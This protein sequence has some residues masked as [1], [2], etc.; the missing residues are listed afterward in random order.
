MGCSA[1]ETAEHIVTMCDHWRTNIMVERHDEVPRV[2]YTA[3]KK[4]YEV[5]SGR[6]GTH[7]AYE[8]GKIK[9]YGGNGTLPHDTALECYYLGAN[10]KAA[11]QRDRK[12]RVD[13][14][15][16][17]IGA[18]GECTPNLRKQIGILKLSEKADEIIERMACAAL[19]GSNR[20][21]KC[22]LAN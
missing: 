16:L 22:H 14:I 12:C 3:L 8:R 1:R 20:L 10:L 19:Q 18:C 6:I 17:V 11:L 9:K 13:I 7:E 5:H 4:K 21:V 2:I 15:P